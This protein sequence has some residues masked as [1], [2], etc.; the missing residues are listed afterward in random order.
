MK[1]ELLRNKL[2][3]LLRELETVKGTADD[4]TINY[5]CSLEKLIKSYIEKIETDDLNVSN[6]ENLGFK[7][8]ILEYDNLAD[9]DSLYNAACE[10]DYFYSNECR[11]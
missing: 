10:V 5:L 7:R 2:Q 9:I 1:K 8:A 11:S 4:W 3:N 6:G